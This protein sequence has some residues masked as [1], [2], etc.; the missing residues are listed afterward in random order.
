MSS[1]E[2]GFKDVFKHIRMLL[3]AIAVFF[4]VLLGVIF[5]F[6]R[7]VGISVSI[8][9][10]FLIVVIIAMGITIMF[11]E[12]KKK[13]K[14]HIIYFYALTSIFV[15]TGATLTGMIRIYP[16]T[17]VE[18]GIH[19]PFRYFDEDTIYG[20]IQ[21]ISRYGIK[22]LRIDYDPNWR[23]SKNTEIVLNV[24]KKVGLKVTVRVWTY[25]ISKEYVEK[26]V[27]YVDLW[28][29][30]N[31]ADVAGWSPNGAPMMS[32]EV[33]KIMQ[34]EIEVIR[35]VDSNAK[36]LATFTMI[37]SIRIVDNLVPRAGQLVNYVGLDT[38]QAQGQ[39][40][41][42]TMINLLRSATQRETWLTEI[43][44]LSDNLQEKEDYI[45][46]G[47]NFAKTN[48]VPR[49]YLFQYAPKHDSLSIG[50]D[51]Y[52]VP[53]TTLEKIKVWIQNG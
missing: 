47:L 42:P 44:S 17:T 5:V 19:Y 52:N 30:L 53:E 34:D 32:D 12:S 7:S 4:G 38:Y 46:W 15:I 14:F 23:N 3:L 28:Q 35:S 27:G 49:V 13:R 43:G 48:G 8:P 31:E 11:Y 39:T 22:Y 36:F 33:I 16:K 6:S 25:T 21:A 10:V 20:D 26:F 1:R 29:I 40:L 24:S 18:V 51:W 50:E 41:T 2:Y 37:F 9:F 45:F